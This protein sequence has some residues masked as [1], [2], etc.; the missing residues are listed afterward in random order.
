MKNNE[1]TGHAHATSNIEHRTSN[2]EQRTANSEQRTA[3]SEQRTKILQ[4]VKVNYFFIDF[5]L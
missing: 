3:N 2:S 4:E 5:V 1:M